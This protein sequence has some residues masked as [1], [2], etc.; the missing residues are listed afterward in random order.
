MK[1]KGRED[2]LGQRG[3]I[4]FVGQLATKFWVRTL[5]LEKDVEEARALMGARIERKWGAIPIVAEYEVEP[6]FKWIYLVVVNVDILGIKD[7]MGVVYFASRA[8]EEE[9]MQARDAQ[10]KELLDGMEKRP[11]DEVVELPEKKER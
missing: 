10:A 6:D 8:F 3:R 9:I 11:F 1:T 2:H 7:G 4:V 5:G